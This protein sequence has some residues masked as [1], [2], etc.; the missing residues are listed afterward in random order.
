M[1]KFALK[2]PEQVFYNQKIGSVISSNQWQH[3]QQAISG[4]SE[5]ESR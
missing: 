3:S 5:Q 2:H 1:S 4:N